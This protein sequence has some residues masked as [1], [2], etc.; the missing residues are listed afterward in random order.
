MGNYTKDMA[1]TCTSNKSDF[2]YLVRRW[3]FNPQAPTMGNSFPD[4]KES[5]TA[6]KSKVAK[7]ADANMKGKGVLSQPRNGKCVK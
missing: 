4:S 2:Q 1:Y 3:T 5:G 6:M 7:S